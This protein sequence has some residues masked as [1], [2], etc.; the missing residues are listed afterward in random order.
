MNW[1][2]YFNG[3]VN[4]TDIFEWIIKSKYFNI[5]L[6]T[7][8]N[9]AILKRLEK[10]PIYIQFI[11]YIGL[12]KININRGFK[13]S[14]N[15]QLEAI[16]YFSKSDAVE[17]VKKDLEIKKIIKEKYKTTWD[18]WIYNTDT[19]TIYNFIDMIIESISKN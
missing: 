13:F 5:E 4:L 15:Q 6:F 8:L 17:Q 9:N 18:Q 7:T 12:N 16:K 10:R 2:E 11:E 14:N 3:F 1:T 19:N